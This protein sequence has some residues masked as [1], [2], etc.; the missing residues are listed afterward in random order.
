[1]ARDATIKADPVTGQVAIS[2]HVSSDALDTVIRAAEQSA[3]L[4]E[5]YKTLRLVQLLT[6][7]H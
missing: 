5:T 4:A 6:P 3:P 7:G 1:M 2:V